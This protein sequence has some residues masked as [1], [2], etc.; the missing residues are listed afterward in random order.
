MR[1][2]IPAIAIILCILFLSGCLCCGGSL[3]KASN[4]YRNDGYLTSEPKGN[5]CVSDLSCNGDETCH[6]GYCV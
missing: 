4:G 3:G 2:S 1:A 6:N 5:E